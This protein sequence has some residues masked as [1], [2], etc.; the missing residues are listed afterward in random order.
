VYG[1]AR[2]G[3]R[4]GC[5]RAGN[6]IEAARAARAATP[7]W[8]VAC[9][10]SSV[11]FS[12]LVPKSANGQPQ[13]GY[14]SALA[15]TCFALAVEGLVEPWYIH[16]VYASSISLE[17]TAEVAAK[18]ADAVVV[19]ACVMVPLVRTLRTR[20]TSDLPFKSEEAMLQ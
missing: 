9:I 7:F 14:G 19:W 6:A 1:L 11:I 5:L 4:R 16:G 15:V 17:V 10:V 3:F 20:L 2:E 12:F 13:P 8:L 18:A